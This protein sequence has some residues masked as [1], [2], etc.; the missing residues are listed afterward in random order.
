MINLLFYIIVL[1]RKL[2]LIYIFIIL[3]LINLIVNLKFITLAYNIDVIIFSI[4]ILLLLAAEAAI[5]LSILL[6]SYSKVSNL[7]T[8]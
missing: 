5:G 7:N 1:I 4:I 6:K 8:L 2:N 3:E